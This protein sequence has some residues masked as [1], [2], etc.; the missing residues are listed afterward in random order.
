MDSALNQQTKRLVE[1]AGEYAG[2]DKCEVVEA[3]IY[4]GQR[5][6]S[7]Q[8][9]H[10]IWRTQAINHH[11][12]R[13]PESRLLNI[14]VS[15][16]DMTFTVIYIRYSR[17]SNTQTDINNPTTIAERDDTAKD[18]KYASVET[19]ARMQESIFALPKAGYFFARE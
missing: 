10:R 12:L 16:P 15:S 17:V 3:H 9:Q 1:I 14:S 7:Q 8:N 6:D 19:A 13:L 11:V 5:A 2:S 4:P 18:S